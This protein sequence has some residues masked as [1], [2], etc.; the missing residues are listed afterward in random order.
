MTSEDVFYREVQRFRQPLLWAVLILIAA[1]QTTVFG[2]AMFSQLIRHIPWGDRPMS[3]TG[4]AAFG[5]AAIVFSFALLALFWFIEL[6]TEVRSDGV[7]C[8]FRFLQRRARRLEWSEIKSFEAVTYRPLREYGGW[9]IR[10]GRNGVAYTVSGNRGV[11]F[12]R[13]EGGHVLIGSQSPE[14]F[15]EA[16][17]AAKRARKA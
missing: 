5:S 17:R 2:M 15:V 10:V 11:R 12:H 6:V 8:R 7:T 9:G 14:A 1:M 3:D 13:R 16:L 4:L